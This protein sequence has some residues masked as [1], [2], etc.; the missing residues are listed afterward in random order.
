MWI[1]GLLVIDVSL[2]IIILGLLMVQG[3]ERRGLV[4]RQHG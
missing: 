3:A 1:A 2:R 4:L